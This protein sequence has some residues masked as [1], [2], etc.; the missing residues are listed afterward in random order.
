MSD[1]TKEEIE[2]FGAEVDKVIEN[3]K[4][5]S[6]EE[7]MWDIVGLILTATTGQS[8]TIDVLTKSLADSMN[9]SRDLEMRLAVLE[10]MVLPLLKDLECAGTC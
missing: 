3:V 4:Y 7:A 2:S 6:K 1:K 8:K 10:S 5:G 9:K